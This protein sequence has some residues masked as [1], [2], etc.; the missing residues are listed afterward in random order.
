MWKSLLTYV[1]KLSMNV[2]NYILVVFE[3]ILLK[4]SYQLMG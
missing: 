4:Q 2:A 3:F 1:K